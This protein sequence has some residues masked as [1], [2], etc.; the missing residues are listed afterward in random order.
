MPDLLHWLITAALAGA[1]VGMYFGYAICWASV[2]DERV[3]KIPIT[4]EKR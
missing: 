2:D 1:V 4:G 3:S